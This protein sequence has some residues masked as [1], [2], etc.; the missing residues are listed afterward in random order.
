MLAV[1]GTFDSA[2]L[3]AHLEQ[4]VGRDFETLNGAQLCQLYAA[5]V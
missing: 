1:Y 4:R 2:A 5:H 3:K